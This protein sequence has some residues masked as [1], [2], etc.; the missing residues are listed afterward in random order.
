[1]G[2]L[3]LSDKKMDYH[4]YCKVPKSLMH[5]CLKFLILFILFICIH[6]FVLFSG[7]QYTCYNDLI[8]DCYC[9]TLAQFRMRTHGN[10]KF[11]S[12]LSK[13]LQ[14]PYYFALFL[15]YSSF[16]YTSNLTLSC[17]FVHFLY[18]IVN[19]SKLYYI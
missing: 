15:S 7:H 13:G 17:T 4:T 12:G 16:L 5:C 19:Y 6:I 11:S 3:G 8:Y 2:D 1:M 10:P 9:Q 18:L 14:C